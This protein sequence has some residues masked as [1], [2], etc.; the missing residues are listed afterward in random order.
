[1]KIIPLSFVFSICY[2]SDQPIEMPQ[3]VVSKIGTFVLM[4]NGCK[5]MKSQ[6]SK[7]S[8]SGLR[9]RWRCAYK[10]KDRYLCTAKATTYK[11]PD[12]SENVIYTGMHCHEPPYM[13]SV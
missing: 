13:N 11:L 8:L 3:Y 5:F 4:H 12:G 10:K 1:M 2:I 7:S 9:T 6:N